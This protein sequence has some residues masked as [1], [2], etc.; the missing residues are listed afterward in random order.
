M[1]KFELLVC[2]ESFLQDSQKES[3]S[4]I[5]ILEDVIAESYP[6]VIAQ[7]ALLLVTSKSNEEDSN[8]QTIESSFKILNNSDVIYSQQ[9]PIKFLDKSKANTRINLG[10]FRVQEPGKLTFQFTYDKESI[11]YNI[12]MKLRAESSP[13]VNLTQTS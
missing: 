9:I 8:V 13:S 5:N 6:T 3:F 2:A 10:G 4:A 7:A 12:K 1:I 11:E